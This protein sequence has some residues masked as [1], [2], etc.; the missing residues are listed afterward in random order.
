MTFYMM[1]SMS[2]LKKK[3][4]KGISQYEVIYKEMMKKG[5]GPFYLLLLGEVKY[6]VKTS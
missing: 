4:K 5:K 1:T 3:K 6:E 2:H